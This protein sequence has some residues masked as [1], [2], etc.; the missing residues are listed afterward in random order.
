M[1]MSFNLA[2]SFVILFTLP[3]TF[4]IEQLELEIKVLMVV[5]LRSPYP[6]VVSI[7]D[8]ISLNYILI[9]LVFNY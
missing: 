1:M 7:L 2:F 6:S 8:F 9:F 5:Q 3:S 4:S